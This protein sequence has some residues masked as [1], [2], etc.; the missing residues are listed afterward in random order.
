MPVDLVT[1]LTERFTFD[2][3]AGIAGDGFCDGVDTD[4]VGTACLLLDDLA[5]KLTAF[6]GLIHAYLF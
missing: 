3:A 4:N 6:K 5:I 2:A 1:L